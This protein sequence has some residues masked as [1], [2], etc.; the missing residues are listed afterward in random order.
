[1]TSSV[2]T[3]VTLAAGALASAPTLATGQQP[4][5]VAPLPAVGAPTMTMRNMRRGER[6]PEIRRAV[7][8]LE[9]ARVD[10]QNADRDFGGHRAEALEATNN[11]IRQLQL[12]LQYDRR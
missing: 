9:R 2:R 3:L 6:H 8:Q 11:A 5:P 7:R 12:A 1:M 10:L 4:A